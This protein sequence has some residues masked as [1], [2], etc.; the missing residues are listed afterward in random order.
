[1]ILTGFHTGHRAQS[2]C[3]T[4]PCRPD[5]HMGAIICKVAVVAPENHLNGAGV[6][7]YA[8]AVKHTTSI[9]LLHVITH[10]SKRKFTEANR[11]Y[12][13]I[14]WLFEPETQTHSSLLEN[15]LS[16]QV[17]HSSQV[18]CSQTHLSF[19]PCASETLTRL[20]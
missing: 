1:M 4:K 7:M 16:F 12:G 6:T 11:R 13:E 9:C 17:L 3:L 18:K 8:F 2:P 15:G 20:H 5:T 14:L 19:F 10:I